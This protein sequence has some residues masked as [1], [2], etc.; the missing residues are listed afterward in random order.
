MNEELVKIYSSFDIENMA[1]FLDKLVLFVKKN[2][3]IFLKYTL[4]DFLEGMEKIKS[5]EMIFG[6]TDENLEGIINHKKELFKQGMN[7]RDLCE[8]VLTNAWDVCI[9]KTEKVCPA[10]GDENLSVTVTSNQN[11]TVLFCEECLFTEIDGFS[12]EVK[13][14]LIPANKKQVAKYLQE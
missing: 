5:N 6:H 3:S 13:E 1:S 12:V 10:C 11:Q 7:K 14:D 8:S 2:H 9:Y 4:P